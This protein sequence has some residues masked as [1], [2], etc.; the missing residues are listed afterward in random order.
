MDTVK[1]LTYSDVMEV[2]L[3]G[4]SG[5]LEF[6]GKSIDE[7]P[8]GFYVPILEWVN[9]YGSNPNGDTT[10]NMFLEYFNTMSSKCIYNFFKK[11]EDLHK[12]GKSNVI[13]NWHYEQDDDD[14]MDAG[15]DFKRLVNVPINIIAME[16][17]TFYS[18]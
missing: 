4:Q 5:V 7:D 12:D 6:K 18:N 9:T 17:F 14:M 8:E 15:E 10:V 2:I 13:I 3:N 16:D 1:K 11:L